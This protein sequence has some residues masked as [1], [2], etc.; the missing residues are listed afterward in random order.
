MATMLPATDAWKVDAKGL[1]NK[2]LYPTT[3][4]HVVYPTSL[5]WLSF[6]FVVSLLYQVL[7]FHIADSCRPTDRDNDTGGESTTNSLILSVDLTTLMSLGSIQLRNIVALPINALLLATDSGYYVINA[8]YEKMK[9][10]SGMDMT[11]NASRSVATYNDEDEADN[12]S[13][14]DHDD[15]DDDDDNSNDLTTAATTGGSLPAS[16][17][18]VRG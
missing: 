18:R 17:D 14:S 3:L 12:D 9:V 6:A 10:T 15:D 13:S 4:T 5:F 11:V 8:V 2:L 16:R 1:S 7:Q